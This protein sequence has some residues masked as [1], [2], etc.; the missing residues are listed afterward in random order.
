[1]SKRNQGLDNNQSPIFSASKRRKL[2]H[3]NGQGSISNVPKRKLRH[4]DYTVGWICPLEVEQIA[5][6][7]GSSDTKIAVQIRN[8]LLFNFTGGGLPGPPAYRLTVSISGGRSSGHKGQFLIARDKTCC[9]DDVS[10]RGECWRQ[11]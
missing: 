1:M 9:V 2:E 7:A 11:A 8:D 6:A 5:A 4:D 3:E 10:R